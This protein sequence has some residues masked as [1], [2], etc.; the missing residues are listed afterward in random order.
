MPGSRSGVPWAAAPA[1]QKRRR[2]VVET[3]SRAV[4]EGS[5]GGQHLE[6][7]PG[8][9]CT[10]D[11]VLLTA[12]GSTGR[13]PLGGA[14]P[15]PA[16]RGEPE[17]HGRMVVGPARPLQRSLRLAVVHV[18]AAHLHPVPLGVGDQALG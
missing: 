16:Y 1:A 14:L 11:Q 17:P 7:G 15:D 13:D 3:P 8:R 10:A 2:R 5:G 18:R 9:P 12:P 6:V 4:V